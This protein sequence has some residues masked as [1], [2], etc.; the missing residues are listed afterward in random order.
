MK[1]RIFLFSISLV[2]LLLTA[3][4]A[5]SDSQLDEQPTPT[6]SPL[7]SIRLPMGYIPNIQYAPFYVAVERGFYKDVGLEIE[8]DYSFET[9]GVTLVGADELQFD[10]VS[11]EQVLLARAQELP[12]V[13]V[14]AW[15]QEYPVGVAAKIDD[16]ILVPKDLEGKKIG[17]PGLFG[18][19]YVGLRALLETAGLNEED[20]QLD[21]IGF[22]QVEALASEQVDAAVIYVNNEPIQLESMGFELSVIPVADYTHLASNGIITN[23]QTIKNNPDLIRRFVQATLR[24]VEHTINDPEA[25][26]EICK[27]YVE[28][29]A[30]LD[31]DVQ[32]KVL[33]KSISYWT[34]DRLGFSDPDS[35]ENMQVVLL[36]MGLLS[37]PL[38]L[39][40]AFT[41]EFIGQ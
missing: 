34:A 21:S 31:Q 23:E 19:S 38:D 2:V 35:W 30:D 12:V 17:I 6:G 4:S 29:L 25:A 13:Y 40:G 18:A 5:S 27:K 3:C 36:S 39:S 1:K 14:T 16:S 8:F 11:G 41:N 26:Y 28:G 33:L 15:W 37:E 32:M 20:V 10:L 24:G 7:T 22:N 9:D